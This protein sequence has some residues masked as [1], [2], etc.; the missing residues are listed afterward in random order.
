MEISNVFNNKVLQPNYKEIAVYLFRYR[1]VLKQ[2]GIIRSNK[3]KIDESVYKTRLK[4]LNTELGLYKKFSKEVCSL[5]DDSITFLKNCRSS[6]KAIYQDYKE[7]MV[8]SASIDDADK[9]VSY[10]IKPSL[11]ETEISQYSLQD[12]EKDDVNNLNLGLQMKYKTEI[13]TSAVIVLKDYDSICESCSTAITE[14]N[15][16][17]EGLF[18]VEF[19]ELMEFAKR[20]MC[21]LKSRNITAKQMQLFYF[22]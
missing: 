7:L 16:F 15:N 6:L 1:A 12:D 9:K 3:N 11:F 17:N 4:S 2:Y 22:N 19:E 5:D 20:S 13:I 10:T 14:L 21:L 8:S 18:S